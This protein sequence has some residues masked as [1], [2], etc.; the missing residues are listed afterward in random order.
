MNILIVNMSIDPVFGGGTVER[1]LQLAKELRNLPDTNAKVLST[2]AG[3]SE[4]HGFDEAEYI[5]LP[6]LSK[7]WYLPA[8]YFG[9]VYQSIKWA[10]MVILSSH[11]TLLNA[12]VYFVNKILG[13]PYMFCPAGALHIFGRSGL[14]KRIYNIIVGNSILLRADRVIAIPKEE[15]DFIFTLGVS[16]ERIA[17][18]PNGISPLDFIFSDTGRFRAKYSLVGAPFILFMGRLNEIKGPDIL[19]QAFI[20]VVDHY[21]EWHLVF[22][23]PDGGMQEGLKQILSKY[24]LENRV[25]F[26][27]FISGEEKSEAYHAAEMLVI[28]S[29]LEAMSIVALEAGICGTPVVMTDQCGFS[30]LV[31]AGGG[32]E[33]GVN[34]ECL[35]D[36]LLELMNDKHRLEVMGNKAQSFIRDNYTWEIAAKRHRQLCHEV[37]ENLLK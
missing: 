14:I 10:D 7:R 37:C 22:A 13:R 33:V 5:L 34:D 28:P 23:G 25:H 27:G 11:W 21:P 20:R 36:V 31:E 24:S 8:P 32:L 35:A 19:L 30:E 1:A 18:I 3:L 9:K 15:R 16:R 17:V 26:I 4:S 12:M 6:C 2:T 29:R